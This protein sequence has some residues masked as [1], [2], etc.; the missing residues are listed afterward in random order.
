MPEFYE[1]SP[2]GE[3]TYTQRV[4]GS[5]S[6]PLDLRNLGSETSLISDWSNRVLTK[7]HS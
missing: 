7:R 5:F 6:Q 1:V 3:V 4:W 2:D